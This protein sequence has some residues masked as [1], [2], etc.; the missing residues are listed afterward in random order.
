MKKRFW[1]TAL[2]LVI[3]LLILGGV[4]YA[5]PV[6]VETLFPGLEPDQI[7]VTVLDFDG[8]KQVDR[9]L[10]LLKGTPEFDELWGEVQALR[11]RRAP[12]SVLVQAL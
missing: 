5:R 7:S 3:A 12:T 1:K 8:S 6:G 2:L 10:T 9:S 4:W 11:F